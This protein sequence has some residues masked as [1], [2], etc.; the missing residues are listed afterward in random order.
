MK[1]SSIFVGIGKVWV[2]LDG[3]SS[4]KEK[5]KRIKPILTKIRENL[6]ISI[7]EVGHHDI[8]NSVV[9]GISVIGNES[10][11]LERY[12]SR[13]IKEISRF[14][15]CSIIDFQTEI[16]PAGGITPRLRIPSSS[17]ADLKLKEAEK[18]WLIGDMENFEE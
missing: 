11:N 13:A 10:K 16:I 7:S 9:L 1:S 4:L 12:L 3:C 5:R 6:S 17:E 18:R 15:N 8:W 2:Q 14:K